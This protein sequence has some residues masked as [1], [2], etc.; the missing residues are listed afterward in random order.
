M[1]HRQSIL[2]S[3]VPYW[4]NNSMSRQ[5]I[6]NLRKRVFGPMRAVARHTVLDLLSTFMSGKACEL[7][8]SPRVHLLYLHHLF[9]YELEGFRKLLEWLSGQNYKFISHSEAVERV[10]RKDFDHIYISFSFDDGLKSCVDASR[11]MDEYGA[12]GC[13]FVN[14]SIVGERDSMVIDHFCR[15]RLNILPMEFMDRADLEDL[16][17]RGHEV[18][19]HTHSHFDCGA[20]DINSFKWEFDTSH[21][22]IAGIVGQPSHFAWPYGRAENITDEQ[23]RY[24]K[25]VGYD[26]AA[27]AIRGCHLGTKSD[28][29]FYLLREHL[30]ADWPLR[31]IQ[32]FMARSVATTLSTVP[33]AVENF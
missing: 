26:S 15:T 3:K 33:V 31:H 14:G 21:E 32:Y 9:G 30:V 6:M 4:K 2:Q 1:P 10:N 25:N 16:V 8:S 27:S 17:A 13:F 18:G 23:L 12:K 24:I 20:L 5:L 19:N 28:D 22:L 29:P 11:V 7:N